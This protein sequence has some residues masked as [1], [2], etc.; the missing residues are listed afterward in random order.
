MYANNRGT[1]IQIRGT[2]AVDREARLQI[3]ETRGRNAHLN[4]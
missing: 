4:E 3:S 1:C 2:Q